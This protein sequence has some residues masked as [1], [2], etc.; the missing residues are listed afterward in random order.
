M[1]NCRKEEEEEEEEERDDESLGYG[2]HLLF[3]RRG[4]RWI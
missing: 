4:R 3:L 2:F 1:Y